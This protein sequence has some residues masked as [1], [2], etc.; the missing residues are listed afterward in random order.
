MDTL[1]RDVCFGLRLLSK[2]KGFAAVAVLA[3]ALGI[4]PN[5]AIFSVIYATLLAPMPYPQPDQ[6]VVVW[7]KIQGSRNVVSAGPLRW[8]SEPMKSGCAW[9]WARA[10]REFSDSFCAKA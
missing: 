1:W 6:L 9:R 2:N 8:P 7:S 4:G 3:L 10:G 5:T